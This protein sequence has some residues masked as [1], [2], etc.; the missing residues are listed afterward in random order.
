MKRFLLILS[1]AVVALGCSKESEPDYRNNDYGYAQF[2]LYKEA[3]YNPTRAVKPMLDYL[4][5][6]CKVKVTLGYGETTIAQTLPLYSVENNSEMGLRSDKL[7]LLTGEYRLVAFSL[8]DTADELIYAGSP[9]TESVFEVVSG[10]LAVHDITVKVAP[11]GSVRF[12]LKKD[13]EDFSNAPTRATAREYTFDEIS[14]VTLTVGQVL[15]SGSVTNPVKIDKLPAKFSM[16]FDEEDEMSSAEGYRTST[17]VC[18]SLASLPAA[19]YRVVS[20]E[21]Y[22]KSKS[23]LE[24]NNSPKLSEFTVEDNVTTEA[25]VLVTLYQS[26]EYIKDYYALYEIWKS[27]DGENW[28]Y[29][30]EN[31][32]K[33]ANWEFNKD[34]DLWGD[35]PGVELHSN[36]RVAKID[37]SGFA[38]RGD[39][40]PAIGQLTELVELY[41]GTHND[42]NLI[43]YD[44]TL[45]SSKSLSE[46]NRTRLE[47]HS[48]YLRAIHPATQFAE[49]C[50][51]ALAENNIHI[52]ATSLYDTMSESD[53]IDRKSGAQRI[54]KMDT[55]HGTMCNG[56]RSLPAEIGKLTKLQYLFIANGALETVPEELGD[57]VSCTD[58]ELYN[59]SKL[60]KFP[61]QIARMPELVS[62]NISNNSQWSASEI[63]AGMDAI[64]CGASKE[65]IQI[66]YARQNSLEELPESFKN[67][68][69]V[70][71]L[72]LA[73]NKISKIHPLGKNVSPVQLYLDNNLLESLPVDGEG[74]FC[75]YAD[76]EAFSVKYNKLKKVP[77]IFS[78]KSTSTLTSVDF[79]GN[80]IDGFEGEEDGTY[81]GIK[82]ETFTLAQNPKLTKYPKVLATTNSTV[83]YIILRGCNIDEIPQGSFEYKNSIYLSSLDLSYNTLKDLPREMHAVNLPYLYGVE[84]S[85]NNFEHFPFEPLDSS[86]LTVFA[87]RS[88]RNAAGE[89]CLREWPE[90]VFNHKGLRGLYLGSNDL[91]KIEDTIST[92]IYY[93]DISD[94]PNIIFDATDICYAWQV[95]AYILIYDKSQTILNCDAMLE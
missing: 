46:R 63:Y 54:R 75:G 1:I 86:Y 67:M 76:S 94:N 7:Q 32:A 38:F 85:F 71:L 9:A 17:V 20:Y 92:L 43:S 77:N 58:L 23:L 36:G 39:L 13:K 18:D 45:D 35:Q 50:A 33:G 81:R 52:A 64:A 24:S 10:G 44:P 29:V 69:K 14:Y 53:I 56:L 37:I 48:E 91:R 16:H 31:W 28:S 42:T 8:Y 79:S 2:K 95:G 78:A 5:E 30:G 12:T 87:I 11:R 70:S 68:T 72:D 47:S 60:T 22:D 73:Y 65:K 62:I 82:V 93:L 59:C 6:A 34:P 51:R 89:R 88:Q 21:V 66:L 27:L 49:P 19:K 25:D 84:L 80:D 3:S 4:A 74:Y 55:N 57:L 40:S 26:D 90:G 83:A 61:L 41:L 15:G